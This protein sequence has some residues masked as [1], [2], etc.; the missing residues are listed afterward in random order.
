MVIRARFSTLAAAVVFAAVASSP[1]IAFGQR[2]TTG[3][4]IGKIVDTS[5]AVMPGV[6]VSLTSPEALGQFTGVT[7]S[8]G[9]YRITNLPPAT[10]DVRAELSGF[11]TVV[12]KA[13]VRLNG[14]T[15]VDFTLSVGAVS[16]TVN[17]LAESPIVDPERAGLSVNINNEALTTVPVTTNRRFQDAWLVVPGVAVNPATQELTGSERRTSLDGADVTDPYG[18]DIFA[19]NLNYDAIQD[20]EVKAL[21]A[22]AS[23]GSSMVGQ[24]MNIVT[25]SGGNTF[26]G[27]AA[28]FVIPDSFNGSNVEGIP[29]NQRVDYQPDLTLGGP[30]QRDR[31][32][33]FS[34]YRRVQTDQ[35]FNNAPVPVQRRGNL[36]FLKGTAQLHTAHRLQVSF[37]YDRTVQA[38]AIVRGTVAPNRNLG[39]LTSSTTAPTWSATPQITAPSAFGTLI[40]GGPL[41]SFNYNWVVNSSKVFQFVG[42][43]MINKPN[44]LQPL[45]GQG[46]IPTKVIQS[47]PQGNILGSLTTTAVEGGFGGTDTSHRSMIYLSP[48]MTFF[49]NNKIGSHEFRGGADLYPNIENKTTSNLAPVE[50]YFRPPGT[51]GSADQL[52]ERDVL[53]GFDGGTTISNDAWEHHYGVYFQDRW[54]PSQ[55]VAVKA[56]VRA[57]TTSIFTADRQAVLGALLPPALPTNTSDQEFHQNTWMPNFGISLDAGS[58]GIF[59]GTAQR[60][61]E[62][63]DLGG[64]DGTSHPPNVLAT[65]ISRANPRTNPTLN[66]LLP[67]GFPLGVNFGDTKDGS[68]TNGRTYVNEFSGGWEHKLPHTSSISTT[69]LWRRNWDYQSGDDYNVIR[70]PTTGALIDRPY[71][72]YDSIINTYNPNY[73]WQQQRSLQLLYTKTFAG[74]WGVNAN[75]SYIL[76]STIRTRWNPTRDQLQFYGISPDDVLSQRTSPRHHA[77]FSGFT[78]LPYDVTLSLFYSYSQGGRFN[79]M[80][81][82]FPLNQ[83]APRVVLS[84]GRSVADPFFNVAYP[85]ARRN[86]V[87]MLKADD[88]HLVNLRV[89]KSIRLARDRKIEFSADVFNLFNNAAATNFLS[90]DIRSSLYAQPTSYVSARVAQLGVRTT[91]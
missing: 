74:N 71:P 58:W 31:I 57:E 55:R 45:D 24:Y 17:V 69:F 84:N 9:S 33:F 23:D 30:I 10:Y 12:R 59:R 73:T 3:T 21:G 83:T 77:R 66:Q 41:A 61:Y 64:G 2:T 4:V 32:W 75:Y 40:K 8:Q 7:D 34:A 25:K 91:F 62:W 90:V 37:Q 18:G 14:V 68:I 38:N 28:L 67:G 50:Y 20:V 72:D 52:F 63:L 43:F 53:R 15:E 46:L 48:S 36:W 11:Q 65:D 80:T 88:A 78:N 49:V 76:A 54:K 79:I 35:T 44:D 1:S 47:N 85:L 60:S 70:N 51:T 87:D 82:D 81:G 19:V 5:G 86:D 16:E 39:L 6:S 89:L 29:A 27:S 26:H 13:P 42:S 22:E 56:G